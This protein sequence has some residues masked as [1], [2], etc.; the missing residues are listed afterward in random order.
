MVG[1]I[2]HELR[3]PLNC[4]IVLLDLLTKKPEIVS[5]EVLKEYIEPS[6]NS[7]YFMMCLIN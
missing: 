5:E 3:T 4:I 6:L 2:S 7:S 1:G